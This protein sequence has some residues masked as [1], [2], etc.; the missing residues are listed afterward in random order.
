MESGRQ[1]ERRT[2]KLKDETQAA[3]GRA[4]WSRTNLA[5]VKRSQVR[6]CQAPNRKVDKAPM[7][8]LCVCDV[9][10]CESWLGKLQRNKLSKRCTN[11]K[12]NRPPSGPW[13]PSSEESETATTTIRQ[14]LQK[15]IQFDACAGGEKALSANCRVKGVGSFAEGRGKRNWRWLLLGHSN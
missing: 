8:L 5:R 1:K 7:R 14:I 10:G 13:I 15:T 11:W 3:E 9:H 2:K 12:E 4:Q 6:G